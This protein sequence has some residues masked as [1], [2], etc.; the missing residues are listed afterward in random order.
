MTRE[1]AI[2]LLAL[3]KVAYPTAYR[4]MD[5]DTALATVAMW[6]TTFPTVP[7]IVMEMAFDR[8]RRESKFPPTIADMYEQLRSLYNRACGDAI[9]TQDEMTR[10]RC[11]YIM[12]HT[13][14]FREGFSSSMDY[15][16]IDDRLICGDGY[17]ALGGTTDG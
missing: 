11:R 2:K 13:E 1:E 9:V 15:A 16:K 7:Y 4:D 3:I 6:H 12:S 10:R 8:F 5:N 17:K 14:Q